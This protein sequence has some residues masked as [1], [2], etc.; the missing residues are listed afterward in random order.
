M[1]RLLVAS[2]WYEG[3][4]SDTLLEG[5]YEQIILTHAEELFPDFLAVRF[6]KIV[7]FE[8]SLKRPDFALISRNYGSW[9]IV[10][11]ELAHHSLLRHVIPQVEVFSR[12]RYSADDAS[13]IKR[14]AGQLDIKRLRDMMKGE[15]PRVLVVVNQPRP[16]WRPHLQTYNAALAIAEV[17][18]SSHLRHIIRLDGD[19]PRAVIDDDVLTTCHFDRQLPRLL[20]V[21][22]PARISAIP[23]TPFAIEFDG[24]MTEWV[25]MGT[26]DRVW[27]GPTRGRNPLPP[28]HT[29]ELIEIAGKRLM[30]RL[31][32]EIPR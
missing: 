7:E 14:Q 15:Q 10:E 11:V 13:Y 32:T 27:L 30:F 22:S 17:F 4:A 1:S 29:F 19:S 2:E 31:T 24:A 21:N 28:G 20:I 3:L 23:S 16:E 6:N 8:D 5:E 12:A 18:R 9:W 26:G 25:K